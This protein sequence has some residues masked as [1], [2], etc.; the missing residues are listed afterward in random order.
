MAARDFSLTYKDGYHT[1][2]IYPTLIFYFGFAYQK[3][4]R[5]RRP[6]LPAFA[7]LAPREPERPRRSLCFGWPS[8]VAGVVAVVV[9]AAAS[10]ELGVVELLP[11][12]EMPLVASPSA[13]VAAVADVQ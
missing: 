11:R 8:L 1:V 4:R 10:K 5:R 6:R 9:A 13:I 7:V 3:W 2:E 12:G